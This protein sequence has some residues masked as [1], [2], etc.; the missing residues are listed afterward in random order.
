MLAGLK[1][2]FL[3][4]R[5]LRRIAQ[6]LEELLRLYRAELREKGVPEAQPPSKRPKVEDGEEGGEGEEGEEGLEVSYGAVDAK[7]WAR[8]EGHEWEE[9]PY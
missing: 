9:Y 5:S 1:A 7:K 4:A 2:V 3:F 8:E 6:A